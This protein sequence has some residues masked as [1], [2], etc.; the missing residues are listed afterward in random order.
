MDDP[1]STGPSDSPQARTAQMERIIDHIFTCA[2]AVS[3]LSPEQ[4]GFLATLGIDAVDLWY[5][6]MHVALECDDGLLAYAATGGAGAS[7]AKK[8]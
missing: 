1:I 2:D 8:G 7:Q 6:M 5:A 3:T 4:H